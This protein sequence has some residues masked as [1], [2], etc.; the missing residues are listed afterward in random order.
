MVLSK[1][2][3]DSIVKLAGPRLVAVAL[4]FFVLF[5]AGCQGPTDV[6]PVI[7]KAQSDADKVRAKAN[8]DND[9]HLTEQQK[10]TIKEHIGLAAPAPGGGRPMGPP[11]GAKTK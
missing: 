11:P 10:Q 4:G 2:Y 6:S 5:A 3:S 7:T 1:L 9:S 8:I